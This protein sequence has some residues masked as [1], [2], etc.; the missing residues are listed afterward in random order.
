M[1]YLLLITTIL[2][3]AVT[4]SRA[5][6]TRAVPVAGSEWK[7][8]TLPYYTPGDDTATNADVIR[9][10]AIMNA[11]YDVQLKLTYT[12]VSGT[13]AGNTYVRVS[14]NGTNW[15]N[16]A[17][18]QSIS[19]KDSTALAN[20]TTSVVWSFNAGEVN[21]KYIEVYYDQSGTGVSAPVTT[22]YYRKP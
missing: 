22:L 21:A 5:Q 20:A 19:Y 12:K 13:V 14:P 9:M 1:K 16:L 6:Y 2:C 10:G 18:G 7:S 15:I 11:K 4:A 17:E 3:F 8:F